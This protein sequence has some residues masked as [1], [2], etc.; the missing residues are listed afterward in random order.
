MT[1][2]EHRARL[3]TLRLPAQGSPDAPKYW[4][5]LRSA[6]ACSRWPVEQFLRAPGAMTRYDV[7]LMRAYLS[8]WIDSPVWEMNPGSRRGIESAAS[9]RAAR[10]GRGE[11]SARATS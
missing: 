3:A 7:A 11:S 1:P 4:K 2:D 6:A 5:K 9:R 8:Q 10:A